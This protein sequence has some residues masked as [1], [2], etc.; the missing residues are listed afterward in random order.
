MAGKKIHKKFGKG[1]AKEVSAKQ[2]G[3][4]INLRRGRKGGC[5]R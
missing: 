1:K 2:E 4:R 3:K 5:F